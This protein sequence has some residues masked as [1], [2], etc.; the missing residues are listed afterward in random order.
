KET[1]QID[2]EALA[3]SLS[4]TFSPDSK[5]LACAGAWNHFALGKIVLNLQNRVKVK[6]REGYFVLMWDT[7]TGKEVRRFAGLRDNI[8]SVAFSP[9]GKTLAASSRDGRIVLW[10]TA[11]GQE[12]LHILAHPVV[13]AGATPLGY[14]G[15]AFAATPALCFAP[16]GKTL[17]SAG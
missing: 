10:E 7:D 8:K 17:V 12:R 6:G 5:S 14:L 9:N 11:T 15:S 13:K 4:L 3:E 16:D 2:M 1:R